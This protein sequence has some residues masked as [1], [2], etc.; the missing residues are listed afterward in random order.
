MPDTPGISAH[1][2]AL[3]FES[4]AENAAE[5]IFAITVDDHVLYA[6]PAAERIL[7]WTREEMLSMPFT[8][9]IPERFRKDH[10]AGLE[11]YTATN[12]KRIRWDGIELVALHRDGREIP[13]EVTF[14]EH[15]QG[16]ERFFT[17]MMRDIT[18]RHVARQ[19]AESR[20]KELETVIESK[21]RLIRGFSHDIKNPLGAVDGYAQLLQDGLMG[22]LNEKQLQAIGRIRGGVATALELIDNVVEFARAEA[23]QIE[24]RVHPFNAD[25]LVRDLVEEHRAAAEKAGVQLRAGR[26]EGGELHCDAIRI[27]Q[28]LA[29]LVTNAIK[30]GASVG[31]EI[32]VEAR[33]EEGPKPCVLF[34]VADTGPGIPPEKQHLLFNEFTRLHSGQKEGSGLGLAISRRIARVLGGDISVDSTPGEGSTFTL[35][36]P[37]PRTS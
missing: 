4:L 19:E 22:E 14:G 36:I 8:R 25:S 3:R 9:L 24:V 28:V 5:A 12:E 7:G 35:S 6:N 1:D 15:E 23:G 30:Y 26:T 2:R 34:S 18:D 11:R 37:A 32:S 31:C 13:V 10:R 27:R 21:A 20:R 33:R 16:G 29:N 17:G